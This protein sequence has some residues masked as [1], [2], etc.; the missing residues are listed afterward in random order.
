M[1]KGTSDAGSATHRTPKLEGRVSAPDSAIRRWDRIA[2]LLHY[3]IN[4]ARRL[5]TNI[6]RSVH[7]QQAAARSRRPSIL[8]DLH[9]GQGLGTRPRPA[10]SFRR[11]PWWASVDLESLPEVA[12][13]DS[14]LRPVSS[15]LA[16]PAGTRVH[17]DDSQFPGPGLCRAP[18]CRLDDDPPRPR[19]PRR[20]RHHHHRGLP[21]R[22][23]AR[24]T[25]CPR[26]DLALLNE[27]TRRS[28]GGRISGDVYAQVK[29]AGESMLLSISSGG[30]PSRGRRAGD[31]MQPG[32]LSAAHGGGD[33][34]RRRVQSRH[35]AGAAER[36]RGGAPGLPDPRDRSSGDRTRQGLLGRRLRRPPVSTEIAALTGRLATE[37]SGWGYQRIHGELLKLGHR[38]SASTI[39]RVL[40][41]LKIP[42]APKRHT[43]TTWR[44]FLHTQAA[45]MLAT[46]FFHVDCAVTLQRLYCLFVMEVG[47]RYAHILGITANPDGPWT[48]QQIRNLL[49]DLD[50]RA[51]DFRF[52]VRD[53]AGQFTAAFER[54]P[55]RGWYHGRE[56]PA[57]EPASELLCGTV[58]A[59]RPD[60]GHRPDAHLRRTA[61]AHN[62]RRVRGPLQRATTPSQ[63]PA[64]PAEARSPCRGPLPPADQAPTRPGRPHQ[65]VRAGRVKPQLSTRGR[66]LE[67]RRDIWTARLATARQTVWCA[68]PKGTPT[69]TINV[70][71]PEAL[72]AEIREQ[73]AA[74]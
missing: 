48:T 72:V 10:G 43:D 49:M 17:H 69:A 30:G 55:D 56:N 63:P 38:V 65:R 2:L 16:E 3:V 33:R 68:R 70:D 32:S 71:S 14:G 50:D 7:R 52:L 62:P 37:N 4:P 31:G 67:P 47:S 44:K 46:D 11:L 21:C 25:E 15:R 35:H 5:T 61:S 53:R 58:R 45:T 36:R 27:V 54:G 40:R 19:S 59:H 39:R 74:W 57:S 20:D 42:P 9:A 41:T 18:S 1:P 29:T 24:G 34:L 28:A 6:R 8:V 73:E 22:H 13:R 51:A 12:A 23:H 26:I 64:P 60:R 66:I